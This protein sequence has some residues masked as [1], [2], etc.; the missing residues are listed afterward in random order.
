MAVKNSNF[1]E[2][3]QDVPFSLPLHVGR[4]SNT[5]QTVETRSQFPTLAKSKQPRYQCRIS[6]R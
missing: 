5:Q 1:N 3:P 6:P 4:P 2:M